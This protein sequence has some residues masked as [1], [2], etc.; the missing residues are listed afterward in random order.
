MPAC[1]ACLWQHSL[2][3]GN[4]HFVGSDLSA[5]I[6]QGKHLLLDASLTWPHG[7]SWTIFR[8]RAC[9]DKQER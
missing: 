4:R 8:C 2:A 9:R 3:L 1:P 6:D 7:V 5:A